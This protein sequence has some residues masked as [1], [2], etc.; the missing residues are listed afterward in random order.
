MP[1]YRD[2]TRETST[3]TGTGA[4]TTSGV[5]PTGCQTLATAYAGAPAFVGYAIQHQTLN[6]WEVGKGTFNG[7]TGLTRDVVR[8]GSGG[9][10]VLVNF[11]AGTKD[12][13]IAMASEQVDNAN[14]GMQHAVA[15]GCCSP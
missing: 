12:V 3:S 10:G 14:L 5:A 11:S 9:V 15:R 4:I 6:E 2:R 8:S 13:F 7:T 1:Q